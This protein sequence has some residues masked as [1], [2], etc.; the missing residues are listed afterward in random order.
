MFCSGSN[1][2]NSVKLFAWSLLPRRKFVIKKSAC[3]EYSKVFKWLIHLDGLFNSNIY[4]KVRYTPG[5]FHKALTSY[6]ILWLLMLLNKRNVMKISSEILGSFSL[7][8]NYNNIEYYR[9]AISF[10]N[11]PSAYLS[12][13][14]REQCIT[15]NPWWDCNQTFQ[16][17]LYIVH[18]NLNN[19]NLY[20]LPWPQCVP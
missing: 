4:T 13:I 9:W 12:V 5:F 20:P 14:F 6:I 10:N 3:C 1:I 19:K 2:S 15:R 17:S 7:N 8:W 11:C 18:L 16:R